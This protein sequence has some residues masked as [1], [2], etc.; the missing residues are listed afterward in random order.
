MNASPPD[1]GG[2][3]QPAACA[4]WIVA[5]PCCLA[6]FEKFGSDDHGISVGDLG[7]EPRNLTDVNR[8]L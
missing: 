1:A 8:A 7:L 5:A 3:D 4:F 2:A 6:G